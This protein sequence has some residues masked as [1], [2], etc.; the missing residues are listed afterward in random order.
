MSYYFKCCNLKTRPLF[1]Y[2]ILK[3]E[4]KFVAYY[5]CP[6]CGKRWFE[7]IKENKEKPKYYFDNA[8]VELYKQ[9]KNRI[10]NLRQ[11]T[12]T[13]EHFYYGY[14]TKTKKGR[15]DTYRMN[16]NNKKEFLFSQKY[17]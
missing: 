2:E 7:V 4:Y 10:S 13:N 8:A 14:H 3:P 5:I 16:F 1:Q 17:P 15:Y 11:G 12:K 6:N 9:W